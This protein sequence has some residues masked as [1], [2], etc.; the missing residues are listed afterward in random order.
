MR[1]R[2][3]AVVGAL[4][5]YRLLYMMIILY[6]DRVNDVDN[7]HHSNINNPHHN[8][9][10]NDDASTQRVND[11]ASISSMISSSFQSL[12]GD[13]T[14]AVTAL[15]LVNE[16]MLKHCSQDAFQRYMMLSNRITGMRGEACSI[17]NH[18]HHHSMTSDDDESTLLKCTSSHVHARGYYLELPE[19]LKILCELSYEV[20]LIISDGDE[21][22]A[23]MHRASMGGTS[24]ETTSSTMDSSSS[25]NSNSE[26]QRVIDWSLIDLESTSEHLISLINSS[27]DLLLVM[28]SPVYISIVEEM[29]LD[30]Y[31]FCGM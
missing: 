10:S 30:F 25:S 17:D 20:L 29:S 31:L 28:V 21:T 24:D 22:N 3:V 15:Q 16:L 2:A 13:S 9:N 1:I 19:M 23:S 7:D 6:T 11:Y 26:S 18:H 4:A 12:D 27:L 5:L 14:A 8:G